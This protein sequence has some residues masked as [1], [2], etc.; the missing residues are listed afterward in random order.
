[1]WVRTRR[2]RQRPRVHSFSS[3]TELASLMATRRPHRRLGELVLLQAI[4]HACCPSSLARV[5]LLV[6]P[7]LF[8][9]LQLF[10]RTGA[11][12]SKT[13]QEVTEGDH[14][15]QQTVHRERSL[16][17]YI[18]RT[19]SAGAEDPI[20]LSVAWAIPRSSPTNIP[21]FRKSY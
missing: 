18:W 7:H 5:L 11:I 1:M 10:A 17:S 4:R 6:P 3:T 9:Y 12:A 21:K 8:F 2:S 13:A 16:D 20:L 14:V 15:G 19:R